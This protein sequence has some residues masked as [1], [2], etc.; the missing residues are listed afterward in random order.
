MA[1]MLSDVVMIQLWPTKKALIDA[2]ESGG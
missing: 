1:I 2:A